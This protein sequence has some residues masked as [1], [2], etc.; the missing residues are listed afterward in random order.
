MVPWMH[1]PATSSDQRAASWRIAARLG[2]VRPAK[3]ERVAAVQHRP[4]TTFV[5]LCCARPPAQV[6]DDVRD[7]VPGRATG[8]GARV[9]ETAGPSSPRGPRRLC[10]LERADAARARRHGQHQYEVGPVMADA[11]DDIRRV[12]SSSTCSTPAWLSSVRSTVSPRASP[13]GRLSTGRH[14]RRRSSPKTCWR[15]SALFEYALDPIGAPLLILADQITAA[16]MRGL[17]TNI[18]S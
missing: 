15:I 2:K 6:S 18:E 1:W 13:T 10:E 16:L 9:E 4:A 17:L 11:L 12:C 8:R 7:R 3:N 14:S 5:G